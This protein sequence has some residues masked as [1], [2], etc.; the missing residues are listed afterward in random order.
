MP[1]PRP[2]PSQPHAARLNKAKEVVDAFIVVEE[3]FEEAMATGAQTLVASILSSNKSGI[4]RARSLPV[5]LLPN[6]CWSF[7]MEASPTT[8]HSLIP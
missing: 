5:T 3:D 8:N 4:L 2:T 1:S 7:T 6:L